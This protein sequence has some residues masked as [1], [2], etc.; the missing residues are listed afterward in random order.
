MNTGRSRHLRVTK[1]ILAF[2]KLPPQLSLPAQFGICQH[3]TRAAWRW[4]QR[5][6]AP[7]RLCLPFQ[8][9]WETRVMGNGGSVPAAPVVPFFIGF[10]QE[11]F[12]ARD[13]DIKISGLR[14][15]ATCIRAAATQKSQYIC[16]LLLGRASTI[17]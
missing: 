16:I 13:F 5:Y 15:L 9:N 11:S 4:I 12:Q 1:G 10:C 14:I 8:A 3:F 2:V 17:L 7:A 6:H